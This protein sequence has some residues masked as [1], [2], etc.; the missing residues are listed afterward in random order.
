MLDKLY[1]RRVDIDFGTAATSA[2]EDSRTIGASDVDAGDDGR[3]GTGEQG[4]VG[5]ADNKKKKK[6]DFTCCAGCGHVF[7][8][9]LKPRLT[10]MA[11][12][13]SISY[14]GKPLRYHNPIEGKQVDR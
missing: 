5:G 7:P 10:C 13:H 3:R 1:Q 14:R 4:G 2:S 9:A 8:L 11:A 6:T 12:S